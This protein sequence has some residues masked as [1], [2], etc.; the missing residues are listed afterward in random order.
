MWPVFRPV[1]LLLNILWPVFKPA[2]FKGLI[3]SNF[4]LTNLIS[5]GIRET[6]TLTPYIINPGYANVVD[7]GP[8]L[9][10]SALAKWSVCGQCTATPALVVL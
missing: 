7:S 10:R 8:L 3:T 2:G 6:G 4:L 5:I 1:E 9:Q